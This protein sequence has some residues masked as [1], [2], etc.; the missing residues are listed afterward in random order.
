MKNT[1]FHLIFLMLLSA[2]CADLDANVHNRRHCTQVTEATC[3][4]MEYWD[5][6]C[7]ACDDTYDLNREYEWHPKTLLEGE[8][9]RDILTVVQEA[10]LTTEDGEGTL[11]VYYVPGHGEDA[12]LADTT[13]VYNNGNFANIEHYVPRIRFLHQAGYNLVIWDYR[14]YGKSLPD[15]NP[16]PEQFMSDARQVWEYAKTQ[17][18]DASKMI[19]YGF[20]LGGVPATEMALSNEQCALM[21]EAI[22]P[23]ISVVT[24]SAATVTLPETFLSAG[25]YDN[26]AKLKEITKPTFV[27]HGDQDRKFPVWASEKLFEAANTEAKDFWLVPGAFHGLTKGAIPEQGLTQYL[28]KLRAFL[29]EHAP[30]CLSE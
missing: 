9:V 1:C 21:L 30:D 22:L 29:V 12:G 10:Q 18:P 17:A 26:V 24:E 4:D 3:N 15:A 5:R 2:A 11:F 14:G 7:T 25:E 27:F 16:T 13:I 23:S 28:D 19:S 20:S 8:S 6:L